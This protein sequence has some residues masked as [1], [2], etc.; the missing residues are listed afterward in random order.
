MP[1]AINFIVICEKKLTLCYMVQS[2]THI[3]YMREV[4]C[5]EHREFVYSGGPVPGLDGQEYTEFLLNIQRAV[6]LSLEKRDLL[7]ALQREHC[8]LKLGKEHF[9]GQV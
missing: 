5:M 2:L 3:F 9:N 6:I 7:S 1:E 8:L 4:F